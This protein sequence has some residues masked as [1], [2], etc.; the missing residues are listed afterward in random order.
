MN[1]YDKR[2]LDL[3]IKNINKYIENKIRLKDL[4]DNLR[5]LLDCLQTINQDWKNKFRSEWWTLEQIY[6]VKQYK[7]QKELSNDEKKMIHATL[8]NINDLLA[9][10][11]Y[12]EKP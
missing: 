10:H 8:K 12:V 11:N 1:E 3:M 5:G 6:A 9:E 2:Q 7:K 4:I